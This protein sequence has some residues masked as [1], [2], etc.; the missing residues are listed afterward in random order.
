MQI[1]TIGRGKV[2][3]LAGGQAL[4]KWMMG[5]AIVNLAEKSQS[6]Q[7]DT[8][9]PNCKVFKSRLIDGREERGKRKPEG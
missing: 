9:S 4:G 2:W 8:R 6:A 3:T 5:A 1:H 7:H